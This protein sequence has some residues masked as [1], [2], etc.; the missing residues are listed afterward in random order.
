MFY[1]TRRGSPP[2]RGLDP[3]RSTAATALWWLPAHAG[4]RLDRD[5]WRRRRDRIPRLRGDAP[6]DAPGLPSFDAAPP[7]TRGCT[8]VAGGEVGGALGSPSH[9]GM[10]PRLP[11]G[12]AG[13]DRLPRPRGDAPG[14]P[15]TWPSVNR[16]PPPTRGC[17]REARQRDPVC[18]GSSRLRG[19]APMACDHWI[20]LLSWFRKD[21]TQNVLALIPPLP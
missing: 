3:L 9:A 8:L 13:L 11:C 17:A 1:T 4:M 20:N 12:R 5:D 21:R 7:P 10:N 18:G 14:F 15:P 16:A 2:T 19:D 6:L